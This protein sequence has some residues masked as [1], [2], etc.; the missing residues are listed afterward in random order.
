MLT[1]K[2]DFDKNTEKLLNT[3]Y[4]KNNACV[5]DIC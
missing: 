1:D 2:S 3:K 5:R 4:G